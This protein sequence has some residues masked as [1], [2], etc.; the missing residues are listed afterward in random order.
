MR[1]I[2]LNIDSKVVLEDIEKP[3]RIAIVNP[4]ALKEISAEKLWER[5]S[6]G[7]GKYEYEIWLAEKIVAV[8][9]MAA[10]DGSKVADLTP[11]STAVLYINRDFPDQDWKVFK[12][13]ENFKLL[14]KYL[15]IFK[16]VQETPE[17][18]LLEYK[19]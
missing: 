9:M 8:S 18:L 15:K 16:I 19:D 17:E 6:G 2:F 10:A 12:N 11:I 3:Q 5:I 1:E 13:N 7:I 4:E 14:F